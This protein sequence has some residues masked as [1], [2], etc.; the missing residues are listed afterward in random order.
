[1]WKLVGH[2]GSRIFDVKPHREVV[3]ALEAEVILLAPQRFSNVRFDI[4][5]LIRSLKK[6]NVLSHHL[7]ISLQSARRIRRDH[8]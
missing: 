8:A 4:D 3:A 5:G 7:K 2:I 1:M 6:D